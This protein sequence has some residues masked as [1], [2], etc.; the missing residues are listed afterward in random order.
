MRRTLSRHGFELEEIRVNYYGSSYYV[1]FFP[2][3]ALSVVYEL[4][5][6]FL[7]RRN[8]AAHYLVVARKREHPSLI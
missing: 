1:F 2:I 3:Y 5:V 4:M 7:R 6:Y 8:L